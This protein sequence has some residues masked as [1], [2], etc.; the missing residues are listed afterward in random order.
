MS[1]RHVFF[2]PEEPSDGPFSGWGQWFRTSGDLEAIEARHRIN[3]WCSEFN[4]RDSMVLSRLRGEDDRE[5]LQAVDE[6]YAHNLLSR[7]C[8]VKYEED[9]RSPDFRLYRTSE[10]VADVELLT[11]FMEKE[12]SSEASRNNALVGGINSRVRPD[13]WYALPQVNDWNRQ[14]SLKNLAKWLREEIANLADPPLELAHRDYPRAVYST[15]KVEIEFTFAPRRRGT[16]PTEREPIVAGGPM[17]TKF[18]ASDR[19][20]RSTVSQ[21][22]GSKYEHRDKPFSVMISVRDTLRDTE[23][24]INALYGD[25]AITIDLA[26][27]DVAT[28]A[29]KRNGVFSISA[30]HPE[31]RNRRLSCIFILTRG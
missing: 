5:I 1:S 31:G 21:K 13:K 17:V 30:A 22:A 26:N 12:F 19:R 6:R 8:D 9:G 29:R 4:D 2:D 18:V 16:P 14:P 25:A 7:T 27:P 11:L 3:R 28:P 15:P 24:V 20:L 10:Y 23:D